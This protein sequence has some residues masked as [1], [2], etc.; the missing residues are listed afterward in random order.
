MAVSELDIWR[1][2]NLYVTRYGADAEVQ[3][4]I[5]ADTRHNRFGRIKQR[6]QI[7]Q[8][9]DKL[10]RPLVCR[11]RLQEAIG[12]GRPDAGDSVGNALRL[13]LRSGPD[14]DHAVCRDM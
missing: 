13:A 11:H 8:Q 10:R 6:L 1:S 9:A 4:A 12:N 5:Q 14:R 3:A 7:V 2:A